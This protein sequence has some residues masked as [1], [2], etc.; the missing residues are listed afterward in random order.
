M[1]L[2]VGIEFALPSVPTLGGLSAGLDVGFGWR[3]KDSETTSQ[4]FKAALRFFR[5]SGPIRISDEMLLKSVEAV[6]E[7]PTIEI[8][9][10]TTSN[11]DDAT[12]ILE[13]KVLP[14]LKEILGISTV[15]PTDG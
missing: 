4:N 13:S 6:L 15:T 7:N 2:D 3:Q 5:A 10:I 9:T 12:N 11:P 1:G 14:F 8:P